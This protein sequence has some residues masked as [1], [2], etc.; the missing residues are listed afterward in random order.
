MQPLQGARHRQNSPKIDKKSLIFRRSPMIIFF[1]SFYF[2]KPRSRNL[3]N[4]IPPNFRSVFSMFR[5]TCKKFFR[6]RDAVTR[7][8]RGAKHKK[9]SKTNDFPIFSRIFMDFLAWF[10]KKINFVNARSRNL[11]NQ[12]P[13]NFRSVFSMFQR[14]P[15]KILGREIHFSVL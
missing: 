13:P 6:S 10:Q 11:Q 7:P 9:S 2:V 12:I 4:Q 15:Q 5:N 1:T 3:H 14:S 8:L